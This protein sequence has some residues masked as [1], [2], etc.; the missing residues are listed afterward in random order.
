MIVLVIIKLG[1]LYLVIRVEN[2]VILFVYD[3]II[4]LLNLNLNFILLNL[5][6][7]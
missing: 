5:F 2:H 7:I 3:I 1:K 4:I 6:I